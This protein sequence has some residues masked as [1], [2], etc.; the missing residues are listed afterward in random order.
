MGHIHDIHPFWLS[1]FFVITAFKLFRMLYTQ[2]L[3]WGYG[4]FVNSSK[5]TFVM[6]DTGDQKDPKGVKGVEVSILCGVLSSFTCNS[7]NCAFL[8]QKIIQNA[9]VG[10]WFYPL[11]VQDQMKQPNVLI[12]M[13]V[14]ILLPL[15]YMTLDC[16]LKLTWWVASTWK[17]CT[18]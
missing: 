15:E 10:A 4:D 16:F 18:I 1:S 9:G 2:I 14:P 13:C 8:K 3:K 6:S 5:R 17:M 12:Q 11:A 7:T